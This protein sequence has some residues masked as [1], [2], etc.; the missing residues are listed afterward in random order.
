MLL[1]TQFST[2]QPRVRSI[3]AA[4]ENAP[5]TDRN[6]YPCVG[7]GERVGADRQPLRVWFHAGG[8]QS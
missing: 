3:S 6:P 2:S 7:I 4:V 5:P 1:D 8:A